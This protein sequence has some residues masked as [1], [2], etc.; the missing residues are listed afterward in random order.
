MGFSLEDSYDHKALWAETV[1]RNID[2]WHPDDTEA[3]NG[4]LS[5]IV[6]DNCDLSQL[7]F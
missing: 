7:L 6:K 3:A 5:F 4:H 2:I 1:E